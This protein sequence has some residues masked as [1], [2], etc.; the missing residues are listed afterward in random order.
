[1]NGLSLMPPDA[2]S[3]M[4]DAQANLRARAPWCS[5]FGG[6][7][8][9]V[10]VGALLRLAI[11]GPDSDRVT[12]LTFWPIVMVAALVG[13]VPAG[14][15]AVLT[16]ALLAQTVFVPLGD[17]TD[18]LSLRVFL[19]G[20]GFIVGVTESFLRSHS[21]KLAAIQTLDGVTGRRRYGLAEIG[22]RP[23]E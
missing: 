10:V 21:R 20:G 2:I 15:T 8:V 17:V 16:S 3:R 13:G 23:S 7:V 5:G 14:A 11:L 6:G 12:Y 1:M 19:L 9:L 4:L 18:W 22:G